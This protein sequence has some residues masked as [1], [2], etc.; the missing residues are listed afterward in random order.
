[1]A[2]F[3]KMRRKIKSLVLEFFGFIQRTSGEKMMVFGW[4]TRFSR[5]FLGLA[6]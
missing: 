2:G 6:F 5:G 3:S 4:G 1:M